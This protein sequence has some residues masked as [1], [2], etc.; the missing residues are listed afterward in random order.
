VQL[1]GH[2]TFDLWSA[3]KRQRRVVFALMLH[4]I[5]TR[6]GGHG[7]GYLIAIAWPLAHM[8]AIFAAFVVSARATPY[9]DSILLFLGTGTV[10][11]MAFSYLGRFMMMSVL[12]TRGMFAFPEV[13]ILDVLLASALLET[14]AACCVTIIMILLAWFVGIDFMP[15]DIVQAPFAFGAAL[16][17][18]L[19]FGLVNGVI[20][21]AVP[22]WAVVVALEIIVLWLAS[23]V[24]IIPDALP[25]AIRN[26]LAY[27][28]VLHVVEWMRSACCEGYGDLILVRGY[29]IAFGL[30]AVF[31]GLL[32]ERAMRG[33]FLAKR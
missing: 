31:L 14:L 19:G 22:F 1:S 10:P 30:G 8:L 6:F 25:E 33:Y 7:L 28:P 18:G 13:K 4:N 15:E 23:G 17:L 20:A 26:V 24:A 12:L 29:P 21:L 3:A 9:G 2:E 11:F 32:L 27:N 16:L 5:R